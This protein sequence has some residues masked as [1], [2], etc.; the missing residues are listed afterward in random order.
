MKNQIPTR[1]TFFSDLWQSIL[2]IVFP[3]AWAVPL[4]FIFG[5]V[6]KGVGMWLIPVLV[7]FHVFFVGF[8][9]D[10]YFRNLKGL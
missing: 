3:N 10:K 1:F 7:L 5:F 6:T 9:K 8:N 4:W 2:L